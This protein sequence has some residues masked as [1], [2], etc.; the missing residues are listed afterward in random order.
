MKII[1][2]AIVA[3]FAANIVSAQEKTAPGT[4]TTK[5]TTTVKKV[6]HTCTGNCKDGKHVYTKNEV[7]YKETPTSKTK[8]TKT[9]TTTVTPQ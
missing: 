5:T 8:V 7:E 1:A 4:T 6:K 9:K 3:F 2:F